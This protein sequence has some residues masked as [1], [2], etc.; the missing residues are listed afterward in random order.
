M[1]VKLIYTYWHVCIGIYRIGNN[2]RLKK[3]ENDLSVSVPTFRLKKNYSHTI[4]E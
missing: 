2:I 3:K 1:R 4:L